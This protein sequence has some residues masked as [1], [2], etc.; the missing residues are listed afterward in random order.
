MIYFFV[1]VV[2]MYIY[3]MSYI[4]Q[5]VNNDKKLIVIF[6]IMMI[7]VVSAGVYYYSVRFGHSLAYYIFKLLHI[8]I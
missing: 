6:N 8:T 1:F 4:K 7:L 2:I 5:Y 3:N